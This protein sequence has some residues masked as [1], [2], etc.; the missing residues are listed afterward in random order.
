MTEPRP[1]FPDAEGFRI[2]AA[3]RDGRMI[4]NEHG[5]YLIAG[6][7]R[8]DRKTRERLRSRGYIDSR[9]DFGGRGSYWIVTARG[10]EALRARETAA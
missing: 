4:V 8:P 9:Y 3:I 1:P 7:D 10:V 6:E 5:R 2:L